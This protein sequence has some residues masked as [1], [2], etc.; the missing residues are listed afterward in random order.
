MLLLKT[1]SFEVKSAGR[2]V[3]AS[4][5]AAIA[6]VEDMLAAARKE[7]DAIKSAAQGEFERQKA[8]GFEQG[9]NEG[10]EEIIMQKME[11]VESS[12]AYLEGM[13]EKM[14]DIVMKA[15]KKCVEEIGDK[16]MVVQI[17]RKAMG[18]V[19]RNQQHITIRVAP[20]MVS[21]VKGRLNEILS[22]F[23]SL[24]FADVV[25]DSRLENMACIL[26]TDAGIVDASIDIQLSAIEKS[27]RKQFA[28]D[29]QK[30]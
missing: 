25:E 14:V 21:N 29:G 5:I 18:A 28:R 13:E 9:M 2:L 6:K 10:K 12:V 22:S 15:L 17:I 30:E 24:N 16:E 8:L 20:D 4:E 23:P 7:A 26:E 1:S 11:M 3:K 19:V 27:M